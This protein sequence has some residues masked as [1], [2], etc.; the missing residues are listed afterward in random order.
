MMLRAY[1][2]ECITAMWNWFRAN[3]H[4]GNP[5]LVCP[6]GA[7]KSVIIAHIVQQVL[8]KRP[9]YRV[10]IVSHVKE[11]LTQNAE[12]LHR[13]MP[14]TPI[15]VWSSGLGQKTFRSVTVAGIQSVYKLA[16]KV[17]PIQLLIVDEAHRIPHASDSMYRQ[18]LKGLHEN[19]PTKIVGLTATPMRLDSGAIVGDNHLF[20]DI[21]YSI[22]IKNLIAQGFLS[23]LISRAKVTVDLSFVSHRGA[24]FDETEMGAVF[25]NSANDIFSDLL[26]QI[27][28]RKHVL[29]FCSGIEHAKETAKRLNLAGVSAGYVSGEMLA[30]ERDAAINAFIAGKTKVL[31]NCQILTT[32][33]D[34]PGIDAVVLLRGTQSAA[35][36]MQMV[37]RGMRTADGKKDCIVL[38]YGGN[39]ERH[40][41]IDC[42]EV[43]SKNKSKV[44]VQSAPVKKCPV[45]AIFVPIS[46]RVCECGH[47]FP[48]NS[49]KLEKKATQ[50][51]ALSETEELSVSS[52]RVLRH[53]KEGKPDSLRIE[54]ECGLR[55]ISEF[56]CFDHGGF[57]SAKAR[58]KWRQLGGKNPPRSVA[59][60]LASVSELPS[61]DT[62]K[63]RQD[64][65]YDRV[66]G[67]TF[68][69]NT[70]ISG[71]NI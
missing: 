39:I 48:A 59:E 4:G 64:G 23:K 47:E 54:Y 16:D 67:V 60:A 70:P 35:L 49:L 38:D 24:D 2:Q 7:G 53:R 43:R 51:S 5:L 62:L 30:Y 11:I 46:V 44:S 58:Q 68:R 66:V 37:G 42:I 10:M 28:N 71:V 13:L 20:S 22:E 52:W 19:Y 55:R 6:T 8:T 18:F 32:G 56:L 26:P 61:P 33:F 34:F 45:C 21:A 63:V 57:A 17:S 69:D 40:G 9:D 15:G 1:Q 12:K 3:P 29:V 50:R 27:E 31:C 36:Y 65:K 14:N 25:S 41:P